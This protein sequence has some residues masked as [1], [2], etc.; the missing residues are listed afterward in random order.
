M[1]IDWIKDRKLLWTVITITIFLLILLFIGREHIFGQASIPKRQG[2]S[3]VELKKNLNDIP[4]YGVFDWIEFEKLPS[5]KVV[6]KG[7]TVFTETKVEAEHAA[8]KTLGV[9]EVENKI[10]VLPNSR[11]DNQIRK[12]AWKKLEKNPELENYG[13]GANPSVHII[14]NRRKVKIF[15]SV[16]NESDAKLFGIVLEGIPRVLSVQDDLKVLPKE[17]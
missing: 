9:K 3:A 14:V 15:G 16:R 7:W 5:G 10:E 4:E 1:F 17:S 13:E 11:V 2:I 12:E 6:L 8:K